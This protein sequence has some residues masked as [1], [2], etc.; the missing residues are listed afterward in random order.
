MQAQYYKLEQTSERGYKLLLEKNYF[1][2]NALI[3]LTRIEFS[4]TQGG[5]QQHDFRTTTWPCCS[6]T[7]GGVGGLRL[8]F[9]SEDMNSIRWQASEAIVDEKNARCEP[10]VYS[11]EGDLMNP[12]PGI[13]IDV[14]V[15]MQD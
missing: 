13:E 2:L 7:Q 5:P 15:D 14:D 4:R 11:P 1:V 10:D 3:R 9:L 8:S 12:A 6:C